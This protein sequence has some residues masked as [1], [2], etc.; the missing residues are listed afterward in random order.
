M[1]MA[2]MT[3]ASIDCNNEHGNDEDGI[4]GSYDNDDMS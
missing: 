2:S 3:V 1:A 4:N